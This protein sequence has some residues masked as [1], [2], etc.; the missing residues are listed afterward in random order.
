MTEKKIAT[1]RNLPKEQFDVLY[2]IS[3]VLNAVSYQESL[4]GNALDLVIEYLKADRGLFCKY[5]SEKDS[6]SLITARNIQQNIIQN[7]EEFSSGVLRQVIAKKE[8]HGP[9]P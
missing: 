8:A 1:L 6:F 2:R 7:L 3:K 4:V 9:S 5:D